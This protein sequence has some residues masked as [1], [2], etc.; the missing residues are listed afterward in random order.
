MATKLGATSLYDV[1][2]A[3]MGETRLDQ[4]RGEHSVQV[5]EEAKRQTVFDVLLNA[6]AATKQKMV[7]LNP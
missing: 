6:M 1:V 4:G 2:I 3:A 5:L 7:G